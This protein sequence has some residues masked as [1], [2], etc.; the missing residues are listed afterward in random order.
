VVLENLEIL[1]RCSTEDFDGH[2]EFHRLTPL[3]RLM[4]LDE[5]VAFIGAA[6]RMRPLSSAVAPMRGM[7]VHDLNIRIEEDLDLP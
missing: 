6:K 7:P 1:R 4:W 2:T 3:Q 5:A